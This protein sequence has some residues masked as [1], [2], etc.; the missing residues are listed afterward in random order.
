MKNKKDENVQMIGFRY[1]NYD[2]VGETVEVKLKSGYDSYLKDI[3]LPAR[4]IAEYPKFIIFE[5]L[6]HNNPNGYGTS[7]PYTITV[8]KI[9]LAFGE[10]RIR[11]TSRW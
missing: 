2:I 7:K 3:W 6:P 11:R 1:T 5:I 10:V 8:H 4:A 9:K